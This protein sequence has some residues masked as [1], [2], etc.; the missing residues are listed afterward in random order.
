MR[1]CL[2][3]DGERKWV[4]L[5]GTRRT[6]RNSVD[7]DGMVTTCPKSRPGYLCQLGN[8]WGL[9]AEWMQLET[10][11]RSPVQGGWDVEKGLRNSGW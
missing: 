6:R 10:E 7:L 3:K 5:V 2:Y 11:A 8:F 1:A 4:C 9:W